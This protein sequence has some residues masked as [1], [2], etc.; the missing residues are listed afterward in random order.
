MLGGIKRIWI[1][2]QVNQYHKGLINAFG[3]EGSQ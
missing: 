3:P 1:N 2:V